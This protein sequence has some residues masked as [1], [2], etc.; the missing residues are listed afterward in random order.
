MPTL[1]RFRFEL[2]VLV[3]GRR[4]RRAVGV[5]IVIIAVVV[6]A[7]FCRREFEIVH[8]DAEHVRFCKRQGV[9]CAAMSLIYET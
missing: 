5:R 2:V 9:E 8:D 4:V 7:G 6:S 1:C 3:L